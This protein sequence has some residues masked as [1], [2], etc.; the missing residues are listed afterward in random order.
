[1]RHL[2][3]DVNRGN[4][5]NMAVSTVEGVGLGILGIGLPD[6]V[7]F[8]SVILKEL[9]KQHYNMDFLMIH[10]RRECIF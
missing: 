4:L 6:I 1:M 9:M 3:A 7:L 8:L 5:V 2:K 10:R